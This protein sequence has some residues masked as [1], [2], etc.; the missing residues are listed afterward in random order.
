MEQITVHIV[1]HHL[2]VREGFC[3]MF[4]IEVDLEV[5]GQARDGRPSVAL[6]RKHQP[7]VVQLD[8]AL[9]HLNVRNCN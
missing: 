4:P 9:P 6:A 3:Q 5:V 1:G 2:V 8:I 7:A